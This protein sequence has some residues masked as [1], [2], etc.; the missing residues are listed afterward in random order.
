MLGTVVRNAPITRAAVAAQTGLT[1]STVSGL[2]AD[3]IEGGL[4]RDIG[5][6]PETG[7]GRPGQRLVPDP[8][9]PVGIGLQVE[10]DGVGGCL[11]DLA[12]HAGARRWRRADLDGAGPAAVAAALGPVLGELLLAAAAGDRPAAGIVVGLPGPP[13]APGAEIG[14]LLA[15]EADAVGAGGIGLSVRCG[16]PLAAGAEPVGAGVSVFVGGRSETGVVLLHDGRAGDGDA[17]TRFGHLPVR[18]GRSRCHCGRQGCV[19]AEARPTR[20]GLGGD[21]ELR[22]AGRALGR[23][24]AGFAAPLDPAQVVL[25]GR[26]STADDAFV[27]AVAGELARH[28]IGPDRLCRSALGPDAVMRGA[29]A[30]AVAALVADP[31]RWLAD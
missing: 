20:A 29:G 9:G 23:A 28:G 14:A 18:G 22:R 12:G 2:T 31:G 25:G 13:G 5:T 21:Q 4:V 24:L 17:A 19:T 15:A 6:G 27:A 30:T 10:T 26:F 7:T 3:L 11:V 8:A 16:V 1:R